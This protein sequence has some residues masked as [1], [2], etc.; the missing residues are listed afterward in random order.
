MSLYRS[1]PEKWLRMACGAFLLVNR[2]GISGCDGSP[3][4][5]T[6]LIADIATAKAPRHE[7]DSSICCSLTFTAIR[8]FDTLWTFTNSFAH[9]R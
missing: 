8:I 1:Q 7:D 3:Y 4:V 2:V 5:A 6:K 9:D